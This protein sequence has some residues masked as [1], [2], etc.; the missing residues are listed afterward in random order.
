[1][2]QTIVSIQN[3]DFLINNTPTLQGRI[4]QGHHLSGLLPNA[5]MIQGIFD[6]ENPATAVRWDYPDGPWDALRNTREF[7]AARTPTN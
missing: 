3:D 6:D 4:W 5:R 2:S 1:M 7:L